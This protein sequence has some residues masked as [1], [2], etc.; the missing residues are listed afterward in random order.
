MWIGGLAL[1]TTGIVLRFLFA[2]KKG[3]KARRKIAKK[4]K[5]LY[6]SVNDTLQE[7]KEKLEALRR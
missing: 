3:E 2:S 7:G 5:W 4:G 1:F 6:D